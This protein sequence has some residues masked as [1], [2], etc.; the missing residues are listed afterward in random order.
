MNTTSI[1]QV[2]YRGNNRDFESGPTISARAGGKTEV[3]IRLEQ[4]TY[5][6]SEVDSVK[7]EDS[8]PNSVGKY[9]A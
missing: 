2:H 8:S 6:L 9:A 1:S 5:G 3:Q 7:P 4:T